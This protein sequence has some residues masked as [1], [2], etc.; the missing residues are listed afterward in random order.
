MIE[1]R[2]IRQGLYDMPGQLQYRV[3][4]MAVDASGGFCPGRGWSEWKDV[5]FVLKDGLSSLRMPLFGPNT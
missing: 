5:P 1:L 4:E 3:Q 2:W